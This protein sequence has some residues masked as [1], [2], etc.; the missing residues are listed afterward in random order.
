MISASDYVPRGGRFIFPRGNHD[1][2]PFDP[3]VNFYCMQP[4][5]G[6]PSAVKSPTVRSSLNV[7]YIKNVWNRDILV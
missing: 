1:F 4:S 5:T 2:C 3:S 7:S 6:Y